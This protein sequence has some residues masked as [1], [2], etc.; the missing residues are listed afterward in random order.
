MVTGQSLVLY[1]RLGVVLGPSHPSILKTVKWMIIVN[2]IVFH[3]TTSVVLFGAYNTQHN[4]GFAM[5]YRYVEKIQMTGFTLQEFI[6]S[7]I[8]IWRTLDIL[9]TADW[10]HRRKRTMR[11]LLL[12]NV[13][14]VIMDVALLVVEYQDRHVIEQAL[15]QVVYSVK[16]KLEFAILSKLISITQRS[17]GASAAPRTFDASTSKHDVKPVPDGSPPLGLF[18][19]DTHMAEL[20]TVKSCDAQRVERASSCISGTTYFLE[21]LAPISSSLNSGILEEQ[22]KRRTLQDDPYAG[23]CR[24]IAG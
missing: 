8:Y 23:A 3:V 19:S 15:K 5:A 2:G 12:I 6:L 9:K 20:E 10:N 22:N 24:D 14:I 17:D 13:L 21:P 4:H 11:E 18:R 16:L 7:A 1:S